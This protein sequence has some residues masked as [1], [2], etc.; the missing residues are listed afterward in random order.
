[1]LREWAYERPYSM[2]AARTAMLPYGFTDTTTT[3]L[4]QRGT[5]TR[6]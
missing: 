1:M 4:T 2:S 5:G 3:V 6:P